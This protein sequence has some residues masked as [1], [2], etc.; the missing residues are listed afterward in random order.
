LLAAEIIVP[1]TKT[2]QKAG[3]II[4]LIVYST[5]LFAQHAPVTVSGFNHDVIAEGTGSS[6]LSTTTK[7]MDAISP[8]NFVLCTQQFANTNAFTPANTYGLPDNGSFSSGG[9]SYQLGS[10][11]GNNAL[12]LLTS[13]NGVLTLGTPA[14]FSSI[15]IV[16]LGT[17][18]AA[19]AS[20]VFNFS[21]G[22]SINPG[23]QSFED[24]FNGTN[25]VV[26]QGFG[27]VKRVNGPFNNTMYGGAPT[28]PRMYSKEFVIPCTK[29]LVSISFTNTTSGSVTQSNRLFI[30]AVSG[31][32]ALPPVTPSANG[33]TL[34]PNNSTT[35]SVLSPVPGLTYDWF[36]TPVGGTSLSTNTSYTT[37]LLNT[38]TTYYVQATNSCA[39][40]PRVPVTVTVTPVPPNPTVSGTTALCSGNSTTLTVQSPVG[41]YTYNWFTTC[42][43]GTVI[44]TGTSF[45]TPALSASTTYFVRAVN[46][47][48]STS[49]CVPVTITVAPAI[50]APIVNAT[51]ICPGSTTTLTV[52]N[53]VPG[54]TYSWFNVA[55][56]GTAIA[57]GSSFTTPALSA[58]STYYIQAQDACYT[59]ARI[60]VTVTVIPP[61]AAPVVNNVTACTGTTITL[62]ILNAAP[63]ATY[64]W[65]NSPTGSVLVNTG[66]SLTLVAPFLAVTYYVEGGDACSN[67]TRT[68]VTV[69]PATVTVPVINNVTICA[70]NTTTLTIQ[71]V[72]SGE[73]YRW[74][75]TATGGTAL[76]SG[77]A[78][79]T[80]SLTTNTT[81][82]VEAVNASVCTGP[83]R[84]PVTVTVIPL[85]ATPVVTAANIT[86]SSI[87]FSWA[88]IANAASYEISLDNGASWTTP[89]SGATGLTH[90][91]NGLAQNQNICIRVRAIRT[92]ACAISSAGTLCEKTLSTEIFI[93]NTFTP[94]GDGKNDVFYVYSNGIK[95]M[96]II[97]FNQWG[98]KLFESNNQSLGWDG[99]YQGKIQPNGVYAYALQATLTD[100][101]IVNRSGSISIVR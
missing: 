25:G 93:P 47:C 67:S 70:N 65:Y 30:F 7:E 17:E 22:T 35:L 40:T 90:Q 3:F 5:S 69:T 12:Y 6:S 75:S 11:T 20:V 19:S 41:G 79:T 32:Q 26:L 87:T 23:T 62:P 9:R 46:S 21:D 95:S 58:N 24:W 86:I 29:T 39:S 100:G 85:L 101:S 14:N 81:Y 34:C 56:G 96:R 55:T 84:V 92:P 31:V 94:N 61:V 73:T 71:N 27:R 48:T 8:S 42:P 99:K 15:S 64:R 33:T 50:T 74:Y 49:A 28:N 80:P 88:A 83:S 1:K 77:T 68:A 97:V 53:I 51:S 98:Q 60:P 37:P 54:N 78:F 57:N 2:M 16:G 44:N 63:G 89:S 4:T 52:Q 13:E 59:S 45:T 82:Y 18:G 38:T 36:N 91:L 76:F 10:Y 72:V 43:A 66:S